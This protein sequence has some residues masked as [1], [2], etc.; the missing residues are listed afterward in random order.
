MEKSTRPFYH[1][2]ETLTQPRERLLGYLNRDDTLA[3]VEEICKL[4][5]VNHVKLWLLKECRIT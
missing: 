5:E 4:H 2:T 1:D 3:S